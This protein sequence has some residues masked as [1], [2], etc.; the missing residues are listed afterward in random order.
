M[1]VCLKIER[2]IVQ[3]RQEE[4]HQRTGVWFSIRPVCTP[5]TYQQVQSDTDSEVSESEIQRLIQKPPQ[6]AL[7]EHPWLGLS[8]VALQKIRNGQLVCFFGGEVCWQRPN[9]YRNQ[10]Y[11]IDHLD[12]TKYGSLAIFIND[13]GPPSVTFDEG[14]HKLTYVRALKDLNPGDVLYTDYG[15][16]HYVKSGRYFIEEERYQEI[17]QTSSSGAFPPDRSHYHPNAV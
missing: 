16:E 1:P 8:V 9:T 12:Q 3:L 2:G 4:F 17:V 5:E 13:G 11:S 7:S 10:N 6:I 15:S 14:A